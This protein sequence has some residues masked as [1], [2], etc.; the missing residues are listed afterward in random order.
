MRVTAVEGQEVTKDKEVLCNGACDLSTLSP[1]SH[2]KIVT[3]LVFHPADVAVHYSVILIRTVDTDAVVICVAF[4]PE[5]QLDE[6]LGGVW[7]WKR[8]ALSTNP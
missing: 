2:E 4:F 1:C 7:R 8:Y 3:R 6:F 5:H